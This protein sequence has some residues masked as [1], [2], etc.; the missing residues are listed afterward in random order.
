MRSGLVNELGDLP[1]LSHF[2]ILQSAQPC[3]NNTTLTKKKKKKKKLI[4]NK[5]NKIEYFYSGTGSGSVLTILARSSDLEMDQTKIQ[6]IFT[7][8]DSS[9]HET[10]F[11]LVHFKIR[12]PC[13]IVKIYP[14]PVPAFIRFIIYF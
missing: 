13:Q 9:E 10:N 14:D 12:R 3:A 5:L 6:F 1:L 2:R 7:G 4:F 11:G 8:S